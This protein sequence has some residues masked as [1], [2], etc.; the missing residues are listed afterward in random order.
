[1]ITSAYFYNPKL[2]LLKYST[3]THCKIR[4]TLGKMD[5]L[6]IIFNLNRTLLHTYTHIYQLKLLT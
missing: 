4:E 2:K 3:N 1:M 6:Y 5:I